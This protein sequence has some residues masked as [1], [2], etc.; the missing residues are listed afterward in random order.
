MSEDVVIN[1]FQKGADVAADQLAELAVSADKASTSTD[2]LT[3]KVKQTFETTDKLTGATRKVVVENGKLVSATEL[4]TKSI[5]KQDTATAALAKSQSS[6]TTASALLAKAAGALATAFSVK[7]IIEGADAW[8][9]YANQLRAAGVASKDLEKT[10]STVADIARRAN[11]DLGATNELYA[12]LTRNA[13]GL[14]ASTADVGTVTETISK[15]FALSGASASSAKGAITQLNQA[16]ASGVLRGDEFNSVME[17]A[18]VLAR[19]MAKEFTGSADATDRLRAMA[20]RGEISTKRLFDAIRKGAVDINKAFG[21]STTTVA[22]AITNLNTS[23]QQYIGNTNNATGATAV[24]AN[25]INL[26][27]ANIKPIA[28]S[29]LVAAAAWGVYRVAVT[30]VAVAQG[31]LNVVMAASPLGL[32]AIVVGT[33]VAAFVAFLASTEA[34]RAKLVEFGTAAL[35]ALKS[36][37]TF[38][39]EAVTWFGQLLVSIDTTFTAFGMTVAN[40]FASAYETVAGW[41]ASVGKLF[42][43]TLPNSVMAGLNLVTEFFTSSWTRIKDFVMGIVDSI[44]SAFN[45]FVDTVKRALSALVSAAKAAAN[46]VGL[47][48]GGGSDA[49]IA[50]ARASGGPVAAGKKYLVGENGPELFVPGGN[51]S[52][53]PNGTATQ[54]ASASNDN[55][56]SSTRAFELLTDAVTAA[57]VVPFK[58]LTDLGR[59][60]NRLLGE[61][62]TAAQA[63]ASA[64]AASAS[65][66]AGNGMSAINNFGNTGGFS[67]QTSSPATAAVT[68][69]GTAFMNYAPT[70]TGG[71]GG[72]GASLEGYVKQLLNLNERYVNNSWLGGESAPNTKFAKKAVTDFIAAIPGGMSDA[73][74]AAARRARGTVG[75]GYPMAFRSG[76][77]FT[78]G[79]STGAD[80]KVIPMRLSPG[81][82]VDVRTRAQVANDAGAVQAGTNN[83]FIFKIETKDAD[84][85]KRSEKQVLRDFARKVVAANGKN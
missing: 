84:S 26:I 32:F 43:E 59:E 7:S 54:V 63:T 42:T 38:V 11:T 3:G 85:F 61:L 60:T 67:E 22:Q 71:G 55:N 27:G 2:A 36:V 10:Q 1:I 5:T 40:S 13:K 62:V 58:S 47:G 35:A 45:G 70:N 52:I 72:S 21:Q 18:P 46:A 39:V 16:F 19:I 76:G 9:S 57:T 51:G 73:V 50:G 83:T 4:A 23:W 75:A 44:V 28:D 48:G 74:V 24:L 41:F 66:A 20:E 69:G 30:A 53:I 56:Q 49:G 31:A 8:T 17:Q 15:A 34:G 77:Q 29:I 78:V 82:Q 79:G 37:G 80:S 81:E 25:L 33:A 14:R 64:A 6:A 65:A 68:S 12:S